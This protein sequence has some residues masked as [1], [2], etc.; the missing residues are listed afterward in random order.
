MEDDRIK[1]S[2]CEAIIDDVRLLDP[3][4]VAS[5]YGWRTRTDDDIGRSFYCRKH[6]I[7][8]IVNFE[9]G[10]REKEKCCAK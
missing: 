1:C 8:E 3:E 5:F 9:D 2:M 7:G 10:K 4:I 6:S